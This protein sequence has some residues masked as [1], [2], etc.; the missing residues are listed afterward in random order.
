[1]KL[2][3]ADKH[4]EVVR[5]PD[6]EKRRRLGPAGGLSPS[7]SLPPTHTHTLRLVSV[8]RGVGTMTTNEQSTFKLA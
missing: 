2:N 7:C 4:Q 1:M 8:K 3:V 5:P 6:G